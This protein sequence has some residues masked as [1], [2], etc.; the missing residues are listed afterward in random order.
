MVCRLPPAADAQQPIWARESDGCYISNP[1]HHLRDGARHRFRH[2]QMRPERQVERGQKGVSSQ[3]CK[4]SP[5][6]PRATLELVGFRC[7]SEQLPKKFTIL[8][9]DPF[10]GLEPF[11]PY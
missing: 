10:C 2:R 5:Q 3:Y 7:C 1:P 8:G 11:A 6:L 4:L 9:T